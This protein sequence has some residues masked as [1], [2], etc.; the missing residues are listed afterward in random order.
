MRTAIQDLRKEP[1]YYPDTDGEPMAE[2]DFQRKPLT[3]LVE[4][5]DLYFQAHQQVYVSGNL[6]IYYDEGNPKK[7]VAPDVFVVFGVPKREHDIYQT[8]VEGKGPDLVIEITSRSTRHVDEKVK[9]DLYRRLGV[10]EYIQYDPTGDY[11]K[12]ALRG[13]RLNEQGR[14]EPMNAVRGL[15][16]SVILT[17]ALLG[18]Q[19]R[20]E[21]GKLRLF[22][23]HTGK[24]L[25]T[26]SEAVVG[27]HYAEYQALLERRRADRAE[28]Q[29]LS[30]QQ[31]ADA[32]QQRADAE[33][34]RANAEQQRADVERQRAEQ[35][36]SQAQLE[37][38]RA[39]QLA[40]R[41]RA[42]GI[43]SSQMG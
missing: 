9:P 40:A 12:P 33:Q 42:L 22:D 15:D 26:Y 24:Y 25:D 31:R 32:E 2:S 19:L 14:Y 7:S 3:Y 17:S 30:E 34:Q 36:E 43:D 18:L 13:R 37:R 39:D 41:L 28:S 4:A 35:A 16:G 27:R 5:L 20:L 21:S 23:P 6:L 38:Q 11:L 29:V 1:I 10:L 8:W